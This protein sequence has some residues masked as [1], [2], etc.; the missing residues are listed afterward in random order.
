FSVRRE[1]LKQ[2]EIFRTLYSYICTKC[3]EAS[4]SLPE[5]EEA[6][7]LLL[8]LLHTP[9]A[10]P[11]ATAPIFDELNSL[12][13]RTDYEPSTTIP[14]PIL[15]KLFQLADKYALPSE[16][17]DTLRA[18]LLANAALQP[19]QVYGFARGM[20][21]Q[22]D[23]SEAGLCVRSLVKYAAEEVEVSIPSVRHYHELLQLQD[24]R[25]TTLEQLLMAEEIFPYGYGVC[26]S[27]EKETA[28]IWQHARVE[29]IAKLDT[30]T[31]VGQEMY[32]AGFLQVN[33]CETCLKAWRSAVAMLSYKCRK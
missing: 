30:D 9:P 27:H 10:P 8:N 33:Q 26:K 3:G 4:L 14:L 6:L 25:V 17:V 19:L 28:E 13:P 22:D 2:S 21:W 24:K 20:G 1:A 29:L 15:F 11:S 7:T 32:R 16:T 5:S 12:P 23:A 31:N 18:H